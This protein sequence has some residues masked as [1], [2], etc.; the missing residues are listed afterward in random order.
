[1][2]SKIYVVIVIV[3][4]LLVGCGSQSLFKPP[5]TAT[6]IPPTATET[7]K[8]VLICNINTQEFG[9]DITG[10]TGTVTQSANNEATNF[11]YDTSGQRSGITVNVNRDLVFESSQHKYHIEGT[12]KLN[13]ITN[14][15]TYDITATSDVFGDPPQT[16]KNSSTVPAAQTSR[17]TD[18]LIPPTSI[19]LKTEVIVL[20]SSDAMDVISSWNSSINAFTPANNPVTNLKGLTANDVGFWNNSRLGMGLYED[21]VKLLSAD[22]GTPWKEGL[23]AKPDVNKAFPSLRIYFTDNSITEIDGAARVTFQ[24]NESANTLSGTSTSVPNSSP[25]I[26]T[27]GGSGESI[28]SADFNDSS[29]DGSFDSG[30]WIYQESFSDISIQQLNGA[31]VMSKP[32]ISGMASGNLKTNR[33]WSFGDF[34]YIE[35]RLKLDQKH[36]G[37]MGNAGFSFGNVGC[38]VQI[39]GINTTPF[40]WCAQSHID[41]SQQWVADYMSGS[42]YIDYDKWYLVRIEFDSNT[43]EFIS[44][45]DGKPF[46]SWQ[47][48]NI[49]EL[50]QGENPISLGVWADNGTAITGYVDDVRL[51]K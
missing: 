38:S 5:E 32:S 1:M 37:E 19:P 12:I 40:I 42:Y 34:S 3:S 20:V 9:F 30:Q 39:Q 10:E 8:Y 28:F 36:R 23:Y 4:L 46:Y 47:P 27:P 15:L 7:P 43:H 31:I 11:E 45:I 17:P 26:P 33:T 49:D 18:T 44:Y 50:L 41:Q 21:V 29:F 25:P 6:P 51:M 14:D 35:A 48:V 13:P 16:C 24:S 22:L 2:R